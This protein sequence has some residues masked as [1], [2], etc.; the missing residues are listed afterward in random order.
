MG[1]CGKRV[2][3]VYKAKREINGSNFRVMWGKIRRP[4]GNSGAVRA[5]FSKNI[6]PKAFGAPCRIMLYP[7]K[8]KVGRPQN[9]W[10]GM[11]DD[12]NTSTEWE[13]PGACKEKHTVRVSSAEPVTDASAA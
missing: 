1:Y 3:Y 7:K 12:V 5:K 11:S 4:H 8:L 9:W 13:Q 6:P 10:N 2:A